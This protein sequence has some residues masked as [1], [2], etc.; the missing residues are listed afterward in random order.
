M[1]WREG[2][3]IEVVDERSTADL[4]DQYLDSGR[5]TACETQFLQLGKRVNFKGR[6]RT[7]RTFEDNAL[8]RRVLAEAGQGQVLVVDGGGSLRTALIGDQIA[9]LAVSNGWAGLVV[10]GAV[11]DV[12]MLT[13][14]DIGIKALGSNPWKSSKTGSGVIDLCVRF[15]NATFRPGQ[16]VYGDADG[17]LVAEGQLD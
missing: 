8:I 17:L 2:S 13:T 4:V 7:V 10:W 16:W 14:L 9:A 1:D 12:A 11:R 3:R 6:V 15:G 5:I